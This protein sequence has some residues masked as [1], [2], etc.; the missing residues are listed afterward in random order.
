LGVESI[1]SA[2]VG[3]FNGDNVGKKVVVLADEWSL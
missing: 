2:F 3:L 1:P